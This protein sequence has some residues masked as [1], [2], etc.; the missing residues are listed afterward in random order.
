MAV[1]LRDTYG[2]ALAKYGVQNK[3]VVVLDADL[4]NSSKSGCFK[5]VCPERFFDVGV[6]EANM[7]AMAA[8]MASCGMIPFINTFATFMASICLV[9]AKTLIGYS[10]YRVRL[11][12]SNNGLTGGY[13][14]ASHHAIDDLSVMRGIPCMTVMTPSDPIQTAALVKL[15]TEDEGIGAAYVSVSRQGYGELYA[16]DET[17]VIGQAKQ[18]C[19]G[20]DVTIIACGLSAWRAKEAAK[21]LQVEGIHARVLDMF[22]IKPLDEKAVVAAAKET[23]AIVTAEEHSV[24]GGLGT[25]VAETLCTHRISIPFCKVG[26]QDCYTESGAYGELVNLYHIG[27]ADIVQAV[28]QTLEKV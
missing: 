11:M 10:G 13:D 4:A 24:I 15:L 26:I 12:G 19:A 8:G 9:S 20:S 14:G 7:T 17:F 1:A 5:A 25:A 3:K 2:E 6:A 22:T 16:S 28:K 18:L 21:Q 23:S 27:V